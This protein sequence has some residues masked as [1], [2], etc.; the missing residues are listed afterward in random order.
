MYFRHTFNFFFHSVL[1]SEL[2]PSNEIN[3]NPSSHA[4]NARI[5]DWE[6]TLFNMVQIWNPRL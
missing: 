4:E 2:T 6:H 5:I 3:P 1:G